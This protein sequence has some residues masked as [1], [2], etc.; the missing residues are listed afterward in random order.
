[1]SRT[2]RRMARHRAD[3]TIRQRSWRLK[4][5]CALRGVKQGIRGQS[6]FFVH[7]FVA[8]MVVVAATVLKCDR[9]E[10]LALTIAIAMVLT[11]ELFN[12]ALE[13]LARAVD[14]GI[15]AHLRDALDIGSA[16]VLTVSIGAVVV[17]LI[18]FGPRLGAMF[19]A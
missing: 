14:L 3:P 16:A 7:F 11:A 10:W 17:G 1:M 12:S 9:I 15:N 13:S 4:F 18:I 8:A 6:S 2:S 19:G 5:A